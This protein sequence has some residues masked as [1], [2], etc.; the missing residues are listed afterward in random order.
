MR[1]VLLTGFDPF[2]GDAVNPSGEAV[3]GV[4]ARW[5]GPERLVTD[6]LPVTFDGAT[7]RLAALLQ[8]HRP[9]VVIATGL[10]GGRAAVTPE[11]VA[12]NLADARIPDNAGHRPQ[13][14]P[15]VDGGPVAYF[16]T[17]PVKAISAALTDRGIPSTVSHTAG[18]FVCNAVMY[19]ALHATDGTPVRTG[20][21]HMPWAAGHGPADA[22]SLPLGVLID[23]LEVA[24]RVSLD[25]E[26]D[27]SA[28]GGEVS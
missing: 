21:I 2:A 9:D 7:A 14:A 23:A 25:A 27:V 3:R 4:A 16:G 12:V 11:R 15:V 18:T 19:A 26:R 6:I 20:F 22:P 5:A 10:A 28:A 13:D 1:T 24:I 17:L 8:E